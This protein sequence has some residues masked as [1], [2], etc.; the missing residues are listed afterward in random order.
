M[1]VCVW[2]KNRERYFFTLLFFLFNPLKV[3][4]FFP[5]MLYFSFLRGVFSFYGV[6]VSMAPWGVREGMGVETDERRMRWNVIGKG[7]EEVER[8]G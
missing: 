4:C 1:C 2:E 5:T 3:T 8:D 7:R 6:Q